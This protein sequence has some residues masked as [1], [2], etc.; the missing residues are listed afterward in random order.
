MT[1]DA[2]LDCGHMVNVTERTE[3]DQREDHPHTL[4][5]F[6]CGWHVTVS[7]WYEITS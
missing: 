7:S 6:A 5:C 4:W 1:W 3:N 2:R